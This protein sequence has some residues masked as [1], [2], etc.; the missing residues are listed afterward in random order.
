MMDF[1]IPEMVLIKKDKYDI[2]QSAL[3][4][5]RDAL[6]SVMHAESTDETVVNLTAHKD[7]LIYAIEKIESAIWWNFRTVKLTLQD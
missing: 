6:T 2:D 3:N 4:Y 1:D 7:D 5:M